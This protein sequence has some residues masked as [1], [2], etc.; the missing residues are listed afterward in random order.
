MRSVVLA[1]RLRGRGEDPARRGSGD[2]YRRQ[3]VTWVRS[4]VLAAVSVAV[5]RIQHVGDPED[6]YRRQRFA[7]GDY[8]FKIS[9]T[10]AAAAASRSAS[11]SFLYL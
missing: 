2:R 1:G 7:W 11:N 4:V 5:V 8:S 6:R 3:R 9:A 10:S